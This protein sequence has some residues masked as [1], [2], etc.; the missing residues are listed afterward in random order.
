MLFITKM[1]KRPR[2]KPTTTWQ[3]IWHFIWY[4]DSLAS[5]I[6]NIIL[7]FLLIKFIVYPGIGFIVGTQLPVVA[8]VS[9]SMDHDYSKKK[10]V[11][12]YELCGYE[13]S[14]R[15]RLTQ[16]GYWNLCGDW[17]EERGIAKEEFF[18]Y[19]LKNGFSKGDIIVLSGKEPSKIQQGDVIV[20]YATPSRFAS[21]DEIPPYPIIHRV[22]AKEETLQGYVFETKGD[23]NP[24]QII[25]TRR[26]IVENNIQESQIVGVAR[27]K[28]PYLGWVKIAL[29]DI[30]DGRNC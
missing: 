21:Q 28:I 13:E 26:G 11:Q 7:I 12:E 19:P 25:D 20:F 1:A 23:H 18:D 5:W 4:E 27:A 16:D 10:C 29:V 24:D 14:S 6:A 3:K 2:K 22:I 30:L 15:T 8:V 9:E 17:Y